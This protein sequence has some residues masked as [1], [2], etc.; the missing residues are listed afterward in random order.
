[1]RELIYNLNILYLLN[2]KFITMC[3]TYI[4]KIYTKKQVYL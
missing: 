3:K 2:V 4:T 1:M